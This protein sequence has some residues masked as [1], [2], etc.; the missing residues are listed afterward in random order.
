MPMTAHRSTHAGPD[1]ASSMIDALVIAA[2]AGIVLGLILIAQ[3]RTRDNG[4][5]F[6]AHSPN[7]RSR[8]ATVIALVD[9]GTYAIDDVIYELGLD[10]KPVLGPDGKPVKSPWYTIDMVRRTDTGRFYSSKPPLF[11]TLLAGEYWLLKRLGGTIVDYSCPKKCDKDKRYGTP[12]PCPVCDSSLIESRRPRFNFVDRPH[13]LVRTLVATANWLPMV[14]FL[15]LFGR[16]LRRETSD[17][18]VRL[19]S[20]L[21]AGLGTYLTGFSVTINNHTIAAFSAFFAIYP[22]LRSGSD[23]GWLPCRYAVAGLFAAFT[24]CNE[25]PAGA[26]SAGL[27]LILV[28]RAPALT[29]SYFVPAAIVPLAAFFWTNYQVTGDMLPVYMHKSWYHYEGSYWDNPTGIDNIREPW[30]LYLT[31]TTVGHHGVF[32][33]TPLMLVCWFGIIRSWWPSHGE[34][35]GLQR[36]LAHLATVVTVIIFVFYI[37]IPALEQYGLAPQRNY[38]GMCNGFRWTFWL[39]PLWL[40][41]LPRGLELLVRSREL[42][43]VAMLFLMVSMVSAFYATRNPWTRPWLHQLLYDAGWIGY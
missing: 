29:M 43:G 21:A 28:W 42:R 12:G 11:P 40:L 14:V 2:S 35:D 16:L 6:P 24:A 5:T 4:F 25:L 22:V 30:H 1:D 38:G 7:D 3:G 32:S 37:G 18:W 9:H 39:I 41:Y 15:V 23:V 31:H 10:G 17:D 36:R 26:F 34:T 8:F 27:F 33:L 13:V 20:L 19:Y